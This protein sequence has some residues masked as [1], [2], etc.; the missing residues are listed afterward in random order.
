MKEFSHLRRRICRIL[1]ESPNLKD[2]LK[3]CK[4]F[5]CLLKVSDS[6]KELLFSAEEKSKINHS[7]NFKELFDIMNRCISWYDLSILRDIIDVCLS[8]EATKEYYQYMKKR[9]LAKGLE[10]HI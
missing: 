6:T 7:K 8:V 10:I 9:D 1:S 2:N 5:C 4:D 3:A